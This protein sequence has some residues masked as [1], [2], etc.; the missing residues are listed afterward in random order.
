ML[1][2]QDHATPL[3]IAARSGYVE[4]A[5]QLVEAKADINARDKVGTLQSL[6]WMISWICAAH[7]IHID[8][9]SVSE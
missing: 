3:Y 2:C 7:T 8:F 6:P 5:K 9:S 4:V 1:V